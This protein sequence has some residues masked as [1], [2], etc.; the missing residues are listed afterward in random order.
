MLARSSPAGL[1]LATDRR[2]QYPAHVELIDNTIIDA[3]A[4][5]LPPRIIFEAPPRHGKSELVSKYTPAWYA[6]TFP[7]RRVMLASYEAEFAA[8]WGRKAR[9]I[10]EGVGQPIFGVNVAED[11]RARNLWEARLSWTPDD[12][13]LFDWGIADGG[14]MITAGVGGPLTGK[15]A[16]LLIVDDPVKN[17][18]EADSLTYR[19]RAWEWWQSTAY[20]RLEPG[21]IAVVMQTR[22]HEDDLAGRL[23]AEMEAGGEE[24]HVVRLPAL[25]ERDDPLGREPGAALW[26][27][28]YDA[29]TLERIRVAVGTYVFEALYQQR[30]APVEGGIFK[31]AWWQLYQAYQWPR[32]LDTVVQSWDMAFKKK[33]DTD[34]VV[35]QVWGCKG[36]DRYLLAQIRQRM[37]FTETK[38]ALK[39]LTGWVHAQGIAPS[40]HRVYVEDKANGSAILS[41]L[42]GV[43]Q[44]L[45]AV[46]PEGSKEARAH[47]VTPQVEGRNVFLPEGVIPAPAGYQPTR[48]EEFIGEHRSFPN[49]ANDDQ[50]DGLSQALSKLSPAR[51]G[52]VG[53]PQHPRKPD[54]ATKLMKEEW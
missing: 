14:G 53:K 34:Y 47:A 28:R 37:S 25:A 38:A 35:G 52:S 6:G 9:E 40:G 17:R 54:P 27:E 4:G 43:V 24:W 3:I 51:A 32:L 20:T 44:G 18:E 41:D 11:V 42:R 21:G 29:E 36:A 7:D 46:E 50:V 23:I 31:D 26:P 1:A 12:A 16:D 45:V 2:F 49:G 10:V 33:S 22:W 15:G 48:T 13:D 19:K 30:P 39:A 5:V 8:T